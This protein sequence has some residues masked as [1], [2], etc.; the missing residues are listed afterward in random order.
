MGK[1]Q[2]SDCIAVRHFSSVV[3]SHDIRTLRNAHRASFRQTEG[4]HKED[5]EAGPSQLAEDSAIADFVGGYL[6]YDERSRHALESSI[7]SLASRSGGAFFFNGVFGSGKSHLL[8]LL[9]LLCDRAGWDSFAES[10]PHLRPLLGEFGSSLTVHFSLDDYAASRNSLEE[11]FWRE[12]Q[13]EWQGRFSDGDSADG[14]TSLAAQGEVPS[15][16][17]AETFSN[18]EE[19]LA[20]AGFDGLV[21]CIDEVSLFLAGREH[22]SLQNDAAFL[23]FL[24]QRTRRRG[25]GMP[26]WVFAALQKTVEDIGDLDSYAISQIRDRFVTLPLSLAHLP[27]LIERRLIVRRDAAA[28]HRL[29]GES[30]DALSRALPRLD[31]GRDEWERLYPFHPAT[32]ALLK[33]IAPRF[34]SRTRSAMLFCAGAI[35]ETMPAVHRVLPARLF[36]YLEPELAAH[37]D[38]RPYATAWQN[39]KEAETEAA[40]D[41]DEAAALSALFQALILWKIAGS[42]PSI[43]QLVN[44]VALDAKLPGDGNYEYGRILLEKLRSYA[45]VTVERREGE[46]TDRYTLDFGARVGEMAR[47]FTANSLHNLAPRDGRIARYVRSCCRDVAFPLASLENAFAQP[48]WRNVPR[49]VQIEVADEPPAP[50]VLAN[51]ISAL[52]AGGNSGDWLLFI[53]PPFTGAETEA[54]DKHVAV[55]R[56]TLREAMLRADLPDAARWRNAVT[57]WLPRMAGDDEW[58]LAREATAQHLL[59]SDPQLQDNRRGRAVLEYLK[60]GLA[61]REAAL[62]RTALRLLREGMLITGGGAVIEA[63]ELAGR[64]NWNTTLEAIAEWALPS[65]F[66]R[67]HDVAPRLRVLT[68]GNADTLCL[69]ILRRPADAPYF[70]ASHERLA[71]AVG[72]PLGV[73]LEERGRWRIAAPREDLASAICSMVESEG[74]CTLATLEAHLSKS[75]WGLPAEL[76]RIALC[77]LVRSGQ[78]A[79]IDARG[80]A[81]APGEIGMPLGRSIRS[82]GSGRLLDAE[83]WENVRRLTTILTGE[84][85]GVRSFAAQ[86]SAGVS[87]VAW[88]EDALAQAELTRARLH[89]LRRVLGAGVSND[90]TS[91]ADTALWSRSEA[92]IEAL[93]RLLHTLEGLGLAVDKLERLAQWDIAELKKT[94]AEWD[95]LNEKLESRHALLLEAYS[96]LTHPLLATPD[97][98]RPAREDL[99]ARMATG[100]A[101][102]DDETLPLVFVAWRESYNEAYA[103]WHGV[104]HAPARWNTL[105][106]LA[107]SDDLRALESL[108]C[109]TNR[110]FPQAQEMRELLAEENDKIC[111]HDGRIIREPICPSCRL[112]LGE[113]VT[114][115]EPNQLAAVLEQGRGAVIASLKEEP[116][117]AH[118]S[119]SGSAATPVLEWAENDGALSELWPLLDGAALRALDEA[120]RPRRCVSRSFAALQQALTGCS[121]RHDYER[122]FA[123]WL[124]SGDNLQPDDEVLIDESI[125]AA[126]LD[127]VDE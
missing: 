68:P 5:G 30:Y 127:A 64:E 42:A 1:L 90:S 81:L 50:D 109:L 85:P 36:E 24:G 123:Q 14:E 20:A 43:V 92:L 100:E 67:W 103:Q 60:N 71:R 87:L 45:P 17:R 44:A 37:P 83:A 55:W 89:Q 120:F 93:S 69:E 77:A 63:A 28:L 70:A 78:L 8:G 15:G 53:V 126:G 27:S 12:L 11:I 73:A 113:R 22:H 79:A 107:A 34:L 75:V 82:F 25:A 56:D 6:G 114:L 18:L 4:V 48:F 38:L 94:L 3:Q 2:I 58:R 40:R 19:T 39:W 35:D 21:L 62:S 117:R 115:R 65:V 84:D 122:A 54:N 111:A 95:A 7:R 88:R 106:R 116:V 101:V 96:V 76:T 80:H 51:R 23:Q 66:S 46:F 41:A 29:C 102:L 105:R 49:G 57:W 32:I 52:G 112:R 33:Q 26:F 31:F 16:S 97:E 121:T 108:S 124:D 98:L 59:L 86:E 104:Q 72:E 119:R 110:S 13:R 91:N 47:R 118:F 10:H 61:E 9:A 125:A 99:L 74:Q